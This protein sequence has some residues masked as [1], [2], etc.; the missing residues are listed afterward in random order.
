[1]ISAFHDFPSPVVGHSV[2]GEVEVVP[3]EATIDRVRKAAS[4]PWTASGGVEGHEPGEVAERAFRTRPES[5]VVIE[6][7]PGPDGPTILAALKRVLARIRAE[8]GN[9]QVTA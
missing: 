8:L 4:G 2:G 7:G 3:I 1:M 9:D 5:V 6:S